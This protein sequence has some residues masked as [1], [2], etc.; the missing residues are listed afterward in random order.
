M[1]YFAVHD[2]TPRLHL[3]M[4]IFPV[5]IH[6]GRMYACQKLGWNAIEL[7]LQKHLLNYM[8]QDAIGKFQV[9]YNMDKKVS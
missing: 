6:T 9:C 4:L 5:N 7:R 3:D 2:H 1:T 8:P